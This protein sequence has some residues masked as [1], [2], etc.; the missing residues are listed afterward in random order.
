MY[1]IKEQHLKSVFTLW[2]NWLAATGAIIAVPVLGLWI[3]CT[4]LPLVVFG[5]EICIYFLS[6][7]QSEKSY[8]PCA[9]IPYLATRILFWSAI[10]MVAINL[11]YSYRVVHRFFD[12]EL[13]NDSIPYIPILIV[14]P[15]TVLVALRSRYRNGNLIFCQFCQQRNGLAHER[16]FIGKTYNQESRYQ[17]SLMINLFTIVS[18][19]CWG[20][21]LLKYININLN[22]ADTF[23]F[24]WCPV[25]IWFLVG[26]HIGVRYSAFWN[27]YNQNLAGSAQQTGQHTRLRIFARLQQLYPTTIP[28]HRFA[29]PHS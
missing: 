2:S 15:V 24:V 3:S 18:V 29:R 6:Y 13:L 23:M 9:L 11:L 25:L 4:W 22:R 17:T 8:A 28:I 14:A 10:V 19:V 26:I 21:Y 16:G 27:Y 5:I 20:Y 12:P 7:N 1:D